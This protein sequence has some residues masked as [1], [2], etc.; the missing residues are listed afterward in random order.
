MQAKEDLPFCSKTGITPDIILN[1]CAL[2]SRMTVGMVL[3]MLLGKHSTITG[4][5]NYATPFQYG[6][7]DYKVIEEELHV[8]GYQKQGWEVLIDGK[9]GKMMRGLIFIGPCTYQALWHLVLDKA[10]LLKVNLP[11]LSVGACTRHGPHGSDHQVRLRFRHHFTLIQATGGWTYQGW[12]STIWRN[13]EG[14]RNGSRS[15]T[16]VGLQHESAQ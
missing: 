8:L 11:N 15:C 7:E 3:E 9:S 16:N 2:P 5:K 6:R 13:G 4:K 1:P 10:E 12:R 14:L